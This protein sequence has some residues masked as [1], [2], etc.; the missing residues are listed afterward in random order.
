MT[1]TF[2]LLTGRDPA[3]L[4]KESEEQKQNDCHLFSVKEQRNW[5]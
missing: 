1:K 4:P 2:L 3:L 5:T